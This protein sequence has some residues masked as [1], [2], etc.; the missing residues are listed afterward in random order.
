MKNWL[1][2]SLLFMPLFALANDVSDAY[3][4]LNIVDLQCAKVLRD[5]ALQDDPNDKEVL[6]LHAKT[7]FHGESTKKS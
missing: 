6:L 7:L 3:E 4:C 1:P 5:Q 2:S